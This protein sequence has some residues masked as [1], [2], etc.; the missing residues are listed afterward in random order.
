MDLRSVHRG[1]VARHLTVILTGMPTTLT[2]TP[3]AHGWYAGR[4]EK[5]LP[6]LYGSN[7]TRSNLVTL[8]EHMVKTF[9]VRGKSSRQSF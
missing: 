4:S 6:Y 3:T 5:L 8:K 7:F 1:A 2:P 9:Y